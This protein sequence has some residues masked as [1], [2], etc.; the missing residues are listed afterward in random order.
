MSNLQQGF[1]G[2]GEQAAQL[3]RWLEL[4]DAQPSIQ[5]IK[6]QMLALG[7]VGAGDRVLD[8]GCGIGLE[9]ARLTERVGPTG[10]AVGIDKSA[11]MIA[12]ARRRALEAGLQVEY[13]IM[14]AR[15]LAFPDGAFDLCRTERVLRY[16]E[17]P[18]LALGLTLLAFASELIHLWVLPG[19][20]VAAMLPGTF[21]LL[22]AACQG[23]SGRAC[24]SVAAGG[25][26]VSE[27]SSTSWL[28]SSGP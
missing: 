5:K 12:E 2:A 4:A 24:R 20:L 15:K 1:Q 16:I 14:D 10:R 9:V 19:Q 28:S 22:V 7:P 3:F 11:Q 25:R 6:R 27:S 21:F 8:V 13:S 26:P 18:G 23:S 17:R